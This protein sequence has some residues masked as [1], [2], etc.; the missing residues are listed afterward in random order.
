[1]AGEDFNKRDPRTADGW[2]PNYEPALLDDALPLPL[3][4]EAIRIAREV[5][6]E[7]S[8]VYH[9]VGHGDNPDYRKSQSAWLRPE[10][11]PPLYKYIT[12]TLNY[13]N[14]QHYRFAIYGMDQIQIIRYDP[15]CFFIDHTDLGRERSA[16]RKITLIIQLSE[17][18]EYQGGDVV[19][20]DRTTVPKHKG[21]GC[22]FPSW[23]LHR[24][25]EITSGTRYALAAWARGTYFN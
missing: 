3:C 1:M 19:I 22:A 12:D 11:A 8:P 14:N 23:A 25:E 4:D 16:N 20:S 9:S 6:F 15:G 18:D 13:L 5:G 10:D 2:E 21:S 17:P 24:V 7:T